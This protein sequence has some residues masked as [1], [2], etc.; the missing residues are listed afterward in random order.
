MEDNKKFHMFYGHPGEDFAIF[1]STF[2]E[3]SRSLFGSVFAAMQTAV[4]L[5]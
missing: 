5:T 2:G 1:L 3:K 4:G